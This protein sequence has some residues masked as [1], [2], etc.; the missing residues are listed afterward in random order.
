[1]PSP[2]IQSKPL[3][4]KLLPQT[5]IKFLLAL[6]TVSALVIL[7]IQSSAQS[8]AFWSKIVVLVLGTTVACFLVYA[9]MFLLAR[10]VAKTTEPIVHALEPSKTPPHVGSD[11]EMGATS[12]LDSQSGQSGASQ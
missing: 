8:S 11:A 12:L 6:M 10:V 2:E 5:S 9:L 1:M 7:L 4:E 3:K